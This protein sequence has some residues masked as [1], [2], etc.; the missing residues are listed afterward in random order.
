[1][2][3]TLRKPLAA[4][5]AALPLLLGACTGAKMLG[6][7]ESPYPPPRAPVVGD[8][9]H[10][11]TGTYVSEEAMLAAVTGPRIVYVGETHDNPAS[12]RLEVTVL[13][14]MSERHPGRVALG[15]E[16]FSPA[17]QET[18]DSWL[19]GDLDDKTFL[20]KT[21]FDQSWN[22]DQ[23]KG[24]LLFA[25]R[26]AIPIVALNAEKELRMAVSRTEFADL[27]EEQRAQLP[28]IDMND[29]Y[30]KAMAEA[31]FAGHD[32]GEA[33]RGGFLR[34][35]TLW[36]E[37]MAESI[38]RFLKDRPD[39]DWRMVVVAGGNHIRHGYGIPRR[40]FRRLPVSYTSVG[41]REIEIP[42]EKMARFMKV[43]VPD[44]PMPAYD[45]Q[46]MTRYESLEME[47]VK[48]GVMLKEEDGKVLAKMVMPD[49]NGARSGLE[50]G[51]VLVSFD[52]VAI[53]DSF[54][55]IYEVKQKRPGDGGTLVI[56]R[57][58]EEMSLEVTFE[59][60]AGQGHHQ[61]MKK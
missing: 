26:N 18:L 35:Q 27:P 48:L 34:V 36:D 41:S 2:T 23:Y 31:V 50:K 49:S 21:R 10:L 47:R 1:M 9:L 54:D 58:G 55:L 30:Q 19:A 46:V 4:L 60:D 45:Y 40:V 42:E 59:K 8:I 13:K 11:A 43:K 28:E 5:L 56:E 37:T 6:N 44:F 39:D 12:H 52:G 33:M 15:M 38:V 61:G 25:K 32:G 17:M 3:L 57:E 14:A 29:P 51:D 53:E 7:P 24:L 16:M 22:F 20:K